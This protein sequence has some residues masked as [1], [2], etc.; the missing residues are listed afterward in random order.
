MQP[1]ES[2]RPMPAIPELKLLATPCQEAKPEDTLLCAFLNLDDYQLYYKSYEASSGVKD[3]WKGLE[4]TLA[5]EPVAYTGTRVWEQIGYT[6]AN[7]AHKALQAY[8]A[9]YTDIIQDS[10]AGSL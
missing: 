6:Q 9:A 4:K 1:C 2:L 8:E 7:S 3:C 10:S 5:T